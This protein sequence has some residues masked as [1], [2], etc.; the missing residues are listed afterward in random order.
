M[1]QLPEMMTSLRTSGD[2]IEIIDQLRLPHEVVWEAVKTPQEAFDAIKSM[3]VS[4]LVAAAKRARAPSFSEA[5][6][7]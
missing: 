7:R 4:H 1:P 6:L 2:D 3:K 5:H